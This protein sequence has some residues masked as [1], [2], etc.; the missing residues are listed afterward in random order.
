MVSSVN[1]EVDSSWRGLS[2]EAKE[3]RTGEKATGERLEQEDKIQDEGNVQGKKTEQKGDRVHGDDRE[4]GTR[5]E[6]DGDRAL[7]ELDGPS[8]LPFVL[9]ICNVLPKFR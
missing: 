5:K 1:F 8:G 2:E 4:Q 7:A 3:M 6:N 9:V